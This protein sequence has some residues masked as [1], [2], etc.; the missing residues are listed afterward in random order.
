MDDR[1]IRLAASDDALGR[2][3]SHRE[4]ARGGCPKALH[5][6]TRSLA[7]LLVAEIPLKEIRA[8]PVRHEGCDMCGSGLAAYTLDA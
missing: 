7:R 2:D 6:G 3:Q 4:W 1:S 8:M 5:E